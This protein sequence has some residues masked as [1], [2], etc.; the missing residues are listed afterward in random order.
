MKEIKIVIIF[1][2]MKK[3]SLIDVSFARVKCAFKK[4]E[5]DIVRWDKHK[6]QNKGLTRKEIRFQLYQK[7][8]KT[9]YGKLGIA[10]KSQLPWCIECF[11]KDLYPDE[12]FVGFCK[13]DNNEGNM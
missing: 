3:L 2:L 9:I 12:V 4:I 1:G 5:G 10:N 6:E 7:L 8:I 13:R 11:I